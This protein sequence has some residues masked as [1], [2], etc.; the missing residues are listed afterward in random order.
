MRSRTHENSMPLTRA[1]DRRQYRYERYPI[2]LSPY[3]PAP[4]CLSEEFRKEQGCRKRVLTYHEAI[5]N[6]ESCEQRGVLRDEK[7]DMNVFEKGEPRLPR[8]MLDESHEYVCHIQSESD[9]R[10]D[11]EGDPG[12]DHWPVQFC[13]ATPPAVVEVIAGCKEQTEKHA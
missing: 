1:S 12:D 3:Y 8:I 2:F 11:N 7:L 13:V 5:T 6:Q 10:K 9:C 4:V